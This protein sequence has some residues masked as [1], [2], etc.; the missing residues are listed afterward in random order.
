MKD[1]YILLDIDDCIFPNPNLW[2]GMSDHEDDFKI[3]EINIKRLKLICE[4][5]D[6]KICIISSMYSSMEIKEDGVHPRKDTYVCEGEDV[7]IDLLRKYLH[8]HIVALSCGNKALDIKTYVQDKDVGKVIV[9][10]DTNWSHAVNPNNGSYWLET[11][12]FITGGTIYKIK[13]IIEG[14]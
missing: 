13:E 3:A 2:C 12:G 8:P 1:N 11:H 9:I 4:K 14:K 6:I 10:E 7:V 5:W